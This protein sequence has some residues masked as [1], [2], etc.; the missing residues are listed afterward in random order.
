MC[1]LLGHELG[2]RLADRIQCHTGWSSWSA[3][4]M[5]HDPGWYSVRRV[6]VDEI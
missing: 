4:L 5:T 1:P 2:Q 3:D 6:G